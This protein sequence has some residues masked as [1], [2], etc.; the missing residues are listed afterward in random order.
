MT[1][2]FCGERFCTLKA[3]APSKPSRSII[4][5][6]CFVSILNDI[7]LHRRWHEHIFI[8]NKGKYTV[9]QSV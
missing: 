3:L 9:V 4:Y 2:Y 8:N 6:Y 5:G 7:Y 1:S